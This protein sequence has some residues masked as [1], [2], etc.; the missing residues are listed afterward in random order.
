MFIKTFLAIVIMIIMSATIMPSHFTKKNIDEKN[1]RSMAIILDNSIVNYYTS[2]NNHLPEEENGCVSQ[3][4]LEKMGL[5]KYL[6]FKDS[7]K[8]HYVVNNDN[9]FTLTIMAD[10]GSKTYTTKHSGLV[11][12]SRV[13]LQY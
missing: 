12:S 5:S 10:N 4:A 6:F 8:F 1:I 3:E 13:P 11:L 9:T 2:H 7:N